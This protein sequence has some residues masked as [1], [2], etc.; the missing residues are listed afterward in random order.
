SGFGSTKL[1][2]KL[3]N[4]NDKWNLLWF[5][6]KRF[7]P[8]YID[9]TI[10]ILTL[11][12]NHGQ[13]LHGE[14]DSN[15]D[16]RIYK[17]SGTSVQSILNVV[18]T[19]FFRVNLFQKIVNHLTLHGYRDKIDLINLSYDFRKFPR[20]TFEAPLDNFK[21]RTA[22]R[23]F[24]LTTHLYP[25]KIGW[26]ETEILVKTDYKNYTLQNLEEFH[27]D[28]N[29][30]E[31]YLRYTS[32]QSVTDYSFKPGIET[33]CLYGTGVNTKAFMDYRGKNFPDQAP[34]IRFGNGDG[35]VNDVSLSYCQG[36]NNTF[37]ES[38]K[39]VNH[40]KLLENTGVINYISR[41][42]DIPPLKKRNISSL[43]KKLKI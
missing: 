39:G 33:H 17:D 8:L 19:K 42:I 31:G 10:K 12:Y 9:E 26:N 41:L 36:W 38:F 7:L 37:V 27:N 24:E 21:F 18:K 3:L 5:S 1:E 2:Y 29:Y 40:R 30:N 13:F 11:H 4:C 15:Y 25:S 22:Q 28:I 32:V 43:L 14:N 6:V 20:E 23:S 35:T 16:I 34:K